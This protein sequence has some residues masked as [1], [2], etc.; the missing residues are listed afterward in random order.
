MSEI[1]N[2]LKPVCQRIRMQTA[3]ESAAVALRWSAAAALGLGVLRLYTGGWLLAVVAIV[4]VV[5]ATVA[6]GLLR[7]LTP[8]DWTGAAR[9]VDEKFDLQDRTITALEAGEHQDKAIWRMQQ[10]EAGKQ[11]AAHPLQTAAPLSAPAGLLATAAILIIAATLLFWPLGMFQPTYA[12]VPAAEA[13]N[14]TPPTAPKNPGAPV[15][16]K[17]SDENAAPQLTNGNVVESYFSGL[18][19][20]E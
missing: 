18:A 5:V 8:N 2:L 15:Q 10:R 16:T 6:Y 4:V 7:W 14:I 20:E 9:R 12:N 1:Q 13:Y 17:T 11:L 19:G 3:I